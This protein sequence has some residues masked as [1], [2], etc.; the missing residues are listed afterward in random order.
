LVRI[1]SAL[2][3]Q[4]GG[5]LRVKGE[6]ID[7]AG[8]ATALLKSWD[9]KTQELVLNTPLGMFGEVFRVVPEKQNSR[10]QVLFAPRPQEIGDETPVEQARSSN[11]LDDEKM[12]VLEKKLQKR[13]VASLLADELKRRAG[14]GDQL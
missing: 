13:R 9:T 7:S 14:K 12:T 10:Q 8:E 1:L 11:T 2:C 6:L 4:S 3:R 5:E